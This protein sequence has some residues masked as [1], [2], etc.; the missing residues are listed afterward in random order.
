MTR[1]TPSGSLQDTELNFGAAKKQAKAEAKGESSHRRIR[2]R[3]SANAPRITKRIPV[4]I[5]LEEKIN[6][7]CRVGQEIT[8][9]GTFPF[10]HKT[11]ELR[12]ERTMIKKPQRNMEGVPRCFLEA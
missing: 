2:R 10:P 1:A 12:P 4:V 9:E 3:V 8:L 5:A 7:E 6:R 11:G